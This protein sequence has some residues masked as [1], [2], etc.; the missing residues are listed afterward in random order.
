MSAAPVCCW[1]RQWSLRFRTSWIRNLRLSRRCGSD[2]SGSGKSKHNGALLQTVNT[3][4]LYSMSGRLVNV[5][6]DERRLERAR[7][8]RASGIPLSDL[9][10]EAIDRQYEELI[11]PSTPRDIVGIMK[12]IYTQFPDPPGLPLRG[13]DIHDRRQARQAILRKLRRKR[14]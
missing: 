9:V 6:L 5:R 10:R 14:K 8:L 2:F 7:R 1:A 13:Y 12:E 3:G 11:K 4:Y